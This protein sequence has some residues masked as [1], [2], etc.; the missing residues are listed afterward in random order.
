MS[1]LSCIRNSL[2]RALIHTSHPQITQL[3]QNSSPFLSFLALS[4][5]PALS[6]APTHN[7][8]INQTKQI[9]TCSPLFILSQPLSVLI[10]PRLSV[11]EVTQRRKRYYSFLGL[12]QTRLLLPN[13]STAYIIIKEQMGA[14][15]NDGNREASTRDSSKVKCIKLSYKQKRNSPFTEYTRSPRSNRKTKCKEQCLIHT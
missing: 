7:I 10:T 12:V 14:E 8:L 4:Q 3:W 15:P 1:L 11:T 2:W 13:P 9:Q 6:L 5:F